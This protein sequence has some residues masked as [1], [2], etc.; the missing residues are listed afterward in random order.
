MKTSTF[1]PKLLALVVLS[2]LLS[3]FLPVA[4]QGQTTCNAVWY[5][6]SWLYRKAITIDYTK[7][8]TGP[9]T[10]FPVLVNI[11]DTDLQA[12][13]LANGND[14]LFTSSNGTTKLDH[15]IESYTSGTGA[16]VAWVEIPSL[17]SAANTVI[18]MYYGNAA[19]ANQQ[20]VT[21]TWNANY[22]GVYHLNTVFTDAT[23]N[24][25]NGAATGTTDVAGQIGRGRGFT[26]NSTDKVTITGLMGSPAN[27]TLSAWENFTSLST[28]GDE[29]ISL[30]NCMLMRIQVYSTA[31]DLVSYF[32]N[33]GSFYA[34]VGLGPLSGWHYMSTTYTAN[35]QIN[36]MDGV[37][38]AS[39]S[40]AI[41][42]SYAGQG[43]NT[44]IGN[45]GN[46]GAN[47]SFAG[48]L[49]E[50]R[51]SNSVRSAGWLLTEFNNQSSPSTFYSVSS[52]QNLKIFTGTG[53]FSTAARWTNS[54]LPIAC[55]YL[56]ID[57]AC[58]VDNSVSTDNI[59]YGPLVIGYT[60]ART[61]N[62]AASGTNRLYVT[63]TSSAFAGSALDMTNGGT[64]KING[65]WTSTNCTFT[66]GTG[67]IEILST[68]TLP[69]AYTTYNNLT[70]TG[71]VT[72]GVATTF[73]GNFTNNGTFTPGAF[74]TTFS[75][76]A[77]KAINGSSAITFSSV[78][79][80][81]SG[82]TVTTGTDITTTGT[83]TINNGTLS[84][85]AFGFAVTG[86]VTINDATSTLTITSATGAKSFGNLNLN[87][88]TYTNTG[89]SP[90]TINGNL[91]NNGTFS[92]GTGRVTFT[93]ATSRSIS[94]SSITAFGGGITVDKG[95][96]TAI[97]LDVQCVITLVSGGLT[98]TNGT[99]KLSSAST[100]T[101]FTADISTAPYLIPSTA[102]LWCDGGTISASANNWSVAGLLRVSAGTVTI[103]NAADANL[104]P[105][106]GSTIWVEGGGNLNVAGRIENAGFT[107]TYRMTGGTMTLCTVGS[108]T[109]SR[110]PF[111][112]DQTG[113]SFNMSGG[114]MVIQNPGAGNLGYYNLATSGTG[115]TGG[116]LQIGNGSTPSST[117]FITSTNP[118]YNL[119]V[120]S[121]DVTAQLQTSALTV[122]NN[123]TITAG[124]L[125]ANNL[126]MTV[127]NDWTNNGTFIPG[128]GR[129]TFNS[130]RLIQIITKAGG[131]TFYNL[132]ANS[133][134]NLQ[135]NNDVMVTNNLSMASGYINLNGNTLTLGNSAAASLT[136]GGATATAYGG[137]FKRWWPVGA[138]SSTAGNLY[139]LFPVGT[140]ND[141]RPIAV[142]STSSPTTAGYV[143]GTHTNAVTITEVTY[144]DNE[145]DA[146]E[147]IQDM[148]STLSTSGVAGGTYNLS[149]KYTCLSATGIL[150]DMKLET[151]TG[152]VMGSVGTNG[153]TAGPVT[154]PTAIRT[155]VTLAQLSNDFVIAT[156]DKIATPLRQYFYSRKSGNWTDATA[157]DATW[158]Y[159]GGGAGA[160][161]DCTPGTDGY[162]VISTG[163]TVSVDAAT[164]V[165]YVDINTAAILNGTA[166]LTVNFDLTT[167]G[168]GQFSPTT[169]I[170]Q[171][172]RDL[173]VVATSSSSIPSGGMTV[174][175]DLILNGALAV[176][177]GNTLTVNGSFN[178]IIGTGSMTGTG[179]FR[180]ITGNRQIATAT[181]IT[182]NPTF[183]IVG[184]ITVANGGTMTLLGNLTGST[185]SSTWSNDDNATLNVAGAVL[186]TGI[187]NAFGVNNTVNYNGGGAQTIKIPTNSTYYNLTCSNAGT[188]TVATTLAVTNLLTI[189]NAAIVNAGTSNFNGSGG[190]TMNNSARL[191]LAD[192]SLADQQLPAFSGAYTLGSATTIE[193]AGAGAQNANGITYQNL[194]ITGNNAASS[195]NI[196]NISAISGNLTLTNQGQINSNGALTIT[197]NLNY[198]S[199]RTS[200]IVNSVTVNGAS[201][202]SFTAGT[203][204]MNSE[205]LTTTAITLGTGSTLL[206]GAG[207]L[208]VT[209]GSWTNNGG[210]FTPETGMVIFAGT[211]N[212]T[213]GGSAGT[214]FYNLRLNNT[215]APSDDVITLSKPITVSNRLTLTDGILATDATNLVTLTNPATTAT[216]RGNSSGPSFVSGPVR[217]NGLT[218]AG[219]FIFPTGTGT[220]DW[221]NVAISG[222]TS[223]TDFTC[224]YNN[225]SY[226]NVS[227][228]YLGTSPTPT[229]TTVSRVE[230]WDVT[231]T[232]G[233]GNAAVTLYWEDASTSYINSC[234]SNGDLKVAHYNTGTNKWENA[235]SS[236]TVVVTGSCSGSSSGTVKSD[237]MTSF[238]PFTFG[239]GSSGVNPLPIELLSFNAVF[240]GTTTDI[241]W[242]TASEINN[243]YFTVERSIDGINFTTLSTI[244][245]K[246]LNGNST[247]T[248]SYALNDPNTVSGVY[249]YRLKQTDFD[250]KYSYSNVVAVTITN[251]VEFSF[252]LAPNPNDGVAMEGFIT[253]PYDGMVTF[254]IYNIAGNRLVM[255]D[256]QVKTEEK[257]PFKIQFKDRLESG[258]YI[259]ITILN[260]DLT[261]K[262][263]MTVV[264]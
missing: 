67:T 50:V 250:F 114:T 215:G 232:S 225:T 65:T 28:N 35:S 107:W 234:A 129:V 264:R 26:A 36:Y 18:Y 138:I 63:N 240:N 184:A 27:V 230:Y 102:G 147:R 120:N 238:S 20:N 31:S 188:K 227:S 245:S 200:T 43:A 81:A 183:S 59:A 29:I 123:V 128:T 137:T 237:V 246:A 178:S 7:V 153:S 116:T 152:G 134:G 169:G 56:I 193:F 66:S 80:N 236:G 23:S 22:A 16:L 131:E 228:A 136:H 54:T 251:N 52:Q 174:S 191:I 17:S 166:D 233:T 103:G 70:I 96:S 88:S 53:N 189:S 207:N 190:L 48:T 219:P 199:S 202:A 221:A 90:I 122:R 194:D 218:G 14:I 201:G 8:G 124:T 15:E 118:I 243:N 119:T 3:F 32:H 49:D 112:N 98:L 145:G 135:L 149:I 91:Q 94:G 255:Q 259:V 235:N 205:D 40:S 217:W 117:I 60:A 6:N 109:A 132:T 213:I 57:G 187:L 214:T 151:Y 30:G 142:N 38:L 252:D 139:G 177:A 62:W 105:Q 25:R 73:T 256:I 5:N 100:I 157:G 99:L 58:T 156:K 249:Y 140:A 154:S 95:A 97:I 113:S 42:I 24:A 229:L 179:T 159:I 196:A 212:Q 239:S 34:T 72:Q 115:F 86:T 168:S 125:T 197:G 61:L 64:L 248:L 1:Y 186:T 78:I 127:G 155:G 208:T 4:V 261:T 93:G 175:N 21:G 223:A 11:T 85:G 106:T 71:A 89:N 258:T 210:T 161:C 181:N 203:F 77:N 148:K 222:V 144:T 55:D 141:Y 9:H 150:P 182:I 2:L 180:V 173:Y 224:Q 231:R 198:G 68:L 111:Y 79:V 162:A 47:N 195:L 101:P 46:G 220:S 51:V 104:I 39:N 83:L 12:R 172:T 176:G 110:A 262:K 13:A 158:S 44:I 167:Y 216:S 37:Q 170:W 247:S 263:L 164:T 33:S 84:V 133:T 130:T 206:A 192:I 19:S 108:T 92:Q 10:N 244:P 226:A 242:Q 209:G 41:A 204:D 126:N 121:A 76:S 74:A 253:T 163:H 165:H 257:N 82:A 260:G 211:A 254:K 160:S 87:N 45:N 241:S 146:I 185:G 171:V 69:A 143:S 75:G